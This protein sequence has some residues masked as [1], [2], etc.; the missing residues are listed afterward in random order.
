MDGETCDV[1]LG[2]SMATNRYDSHQNIENSFKNNVLA[3]RTRRHQRK[4]T[5]RSKN[6]ESIR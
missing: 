3:Y 6:S 1:T 4:T 2:D 5:R